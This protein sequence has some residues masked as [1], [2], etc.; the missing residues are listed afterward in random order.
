MIKSYYRFEIREGFFMRIIDDF[1][2]KVS[3]EIRKEIIKVSCGKEVPIYYIN[4]PS[5][6]H[7]FV[8]YCKY[9]NRNY[10]VYIRGQNDIY[11]GTLIPSLFRNIKNSEN[12]IRTF[13][14]RINS[15]LS[16]NDTFSKYNKLIFEALIQHY[17]IKTT[18]IDVVDNLWVALWF[19]SN[20]FC[21]KAIKSNEHL[22][23]FNSTNEYGYII[24]LASDA[25]KAAKKTKGIYE[26]K[27][28]LIIDLRKALPS[29][30]LRPH[31]QHAFMLRKKAIG[32]KSAKKLVD[33]TDL[34]VGVAKIKTETIQEWIGT[35]KLLSVNSLFPSACF[36]SG[37]EL[38][39]NKYP[40]PKH[41]V[42]KTQGSI[43]IISS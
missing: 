26:G 10:N 16:Y 36:D 32:D 18:Q 40:E 21:C 35:S 23:S 14:E 31:A 9:V 29:F 20:E 19:A 28:T 34:I 12:A 15:I 17:G 25:I 3:T 13:Y 5:E 42:I 43:Q 27:E 6:L 24:L 22:F 1:E 7:Q 4:S 2:K 33:Y 30:Y 38:L 41:S 8:G 39:L 11:N 37:F